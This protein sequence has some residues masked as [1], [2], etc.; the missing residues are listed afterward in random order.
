MFSDGYFNDVSSGSTTGGG[1]SGGVVNTDAVN[2]LINTALDPVKAEVS[3]KASTTAL[4]TVDLKVANLDN[5]LGTQYYNAA[6]TENNFAKWIDVFTTTVD[7]STPRFSATAHG[8]DHLYPKLT[9]LFTSATATTTKVPRFAT[10]GAVASLTDQLTST[11]ANTAPLV[12]N[13]DSAYAS[14][15]VF[16]EVEQVV[17]DP[18]TKVAKLATTIAL[19]NGLDAKINRNLVWDSVNNL[20]LWEAYFASQALN[21]VLNTRMDPIDKDPGNLV[22][23]VA[24]LESGKANTDHNHDGVYA[25]AGHTHPPTVVSTDVA[26]I[27]PVSA[28][29][30]SNF[31]IKNLSDW[32]KL[33]L[34]N[35]TSNGTMTIELFDIADFDSFGTTSDVNPLELEIMNMSDQSVL[36]VNFPYATNPFSYTV[37]MV[38][39]VSQMKQVVYSRF[40][41][42][43]ISPRGSVMLKMITKVATTPSPALPLGGPLWLLG[44]M[45]AGTLQAA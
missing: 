1:T 31:T 28:V 5:T 42:T 39:T 18:V 15:T 8:H 21:F 27:R 30:T 41:Y 12:H 4:N 40:G 22:T 7:K 45:L 2:T 25:L 13:H 34:W 14:K 23:R 38:G 26:L 29:Q 35:G 3:T 37:F 17:R 16:D 24:T 11:I 33:W 32:G 9:D 36:T 43:R 6:Y 19:Q 44:Y 10:T 20:P